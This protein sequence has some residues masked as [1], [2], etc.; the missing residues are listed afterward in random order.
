MIT[1]GTA[2]TFFIS[3][4]TGLMPLVVAF[5]DDAGPMYCARSTSRRGWY[6]VSALAGAT[7]AGAAL[8]LDAATW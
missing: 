4:L 3:P 6:S 2:G 7:G 5:N 8:A 1:S